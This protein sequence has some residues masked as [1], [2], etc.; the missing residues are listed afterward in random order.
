MG[1]GVGDE[2]QGFGP[3]GLV[4]GWLSSRLVR[5]RDGGGWLRCWEIGFVGVRHWFV[6][7]L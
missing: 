6:G 1:L 3:I 5:G 4:D 2:L 7:W